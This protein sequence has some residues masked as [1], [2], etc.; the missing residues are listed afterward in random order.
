MLTLARLRLTRILAAFLIPAATLSADFVVSVSSEVQNVYPTVY[1]SGTHVILGTDEA[2]VAAATG[3]QWFHDGAPIAGAVNPQLELVRLDA[4]D[5]GNYRL[6]VSRGDHTEFSSNT[7]VINVAPAAPSVVDTTFAAP[8]DL[9]TSDYTAPPTEAGRVLARTSQGRV[10]TSRAPFSFDR[11]GLAL[12]LTLPTDFDGQQVLTEAVVRTDGSFFLRQGNR[13]A[14]FAADGTLDSGFRFQAPSPSRLESVILD[15]LERPLVTLRFPNHESPDNYT[16]GR[17]TT[18]RL[19]PDG[20]FDPAFAG[21]RT[22]VLYS[23]LT[24]Y[25]LV[26]GRC[27]VYEAYHGYSGLYLIREDGSP[28][29]MVSPASGV[30]TDQPR[31]DP[32]RGL[33]YFLPAVPA[34]PYRYRITSNAIETDAD[35]FP[36]YQRPLHSSYTVNSDGSFYLYGEFDSW[37]GHLTTNV[38][39]LHPD[40]SLPGGPLPTAFIVGGKSNITRGANVTLTAIPRG[41]GPFSYQWIA[42]DRQP[43]PANTTGPTLEIADVQ[44][45]NLGRYQLRISGP[46]GSTLSGVAKLA[47]ENSVAGLANLSARAVPGDGEDAMIVGFGVQRPSS[48]ST[49]SFLLRGV[50][51]SLQ[52]HGVAAP[53]ADPSLKLFTVDGTQIDANDNWTDNPAKDLI[54]ERS[55][56]LGAFP[57][58]EPSLDAALLVGVQQ[59]GSLTVHLN[60]NPAD[61]GPALLEVYEIADL[62]NFFRYATLANLSLR[63]RSAP[64]DATATA[65]FVLTDPLGF[66]R[67]RRLLLRAV[68]PTLASYGITH[69]LPDPVLTLRNAAGEVLM[70]VDNRDDV[71]DTDQ[72]AAIEAA[73]GAFEVP[74]DSLDAAFV[75][76]LPPGVYTLA[77]SDRNDASGV[78]ILEI[79]LIP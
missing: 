9:P 73:V 11:N 10:L 45:E 30:G 33:I 37:D 14:R 8:A 1:A 52:D 47:A 16:N 31:V 2:T 6:Q 42:L 19:L 51:P 38:A 39:R 15:F 70:S 13:L 54:R 28:D 20:T 40:V 3:Y 63:A 34:P 56:Q 49:G 22:S 23:H 36:G 17:D 29:P 74:P 71:A 50:G 79:Y 72:L 75:I 44:L 57:L 21:P 55:A 18:H 7:I 5:A 68:G 76:E 12:P 32:F 69:P 25:P 48:G 27:V 61:Q 64:G 58:R 35:F 53:L 43:L 67:P 62:Q 65:G 46:G 41:S 59:S 26:D 78:V 4:A 60:R 24:L 66:D 77:A